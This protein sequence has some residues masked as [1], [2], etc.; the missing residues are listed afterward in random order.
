MYKR[1]VLALLAQLR[2][3]GKDPRLLQK[4]LT[5]WLR[6]LLLIKVCREPE[7]LLALSQEE[8]EGLTAQAGVWTEPRPVS[9]THLDVYKR[10]L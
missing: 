3:Q 8:T 4:H 6:N 7:P 2:A 10:Q 1:Q 5:Y 9:Y